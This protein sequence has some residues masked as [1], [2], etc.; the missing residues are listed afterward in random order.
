MRVFLHC[1]R[2]AHEDRNSHSHHRIEM[3]E[4]VAQSKLL[5][6][7][8][9]AKAFPLAAEVSAPYQHRKIAAALHPKAL[10]FL[11]G[12]RCAMGSVTM[13]VDN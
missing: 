8:H 9:R 13:G 7:L 12:F 4:A 10:L 2:G 11:V 3:E 6:V 1:L 5:S